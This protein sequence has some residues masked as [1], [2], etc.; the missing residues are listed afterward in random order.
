MTWIRHGFQTMFCVQEHYPY[1]KNW[2]WLCS[3]VPLAVI[4]KV[5]QMI[6]LWLFSPNLLW[7]VLEPLAL[8]PGRVP[9]CCVG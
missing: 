8:H 7:K 4:H 5:Q 9:L 1:A 3:A 2:I 6:D